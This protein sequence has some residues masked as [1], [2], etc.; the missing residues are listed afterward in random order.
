MNLTITP[1]IQNL[2]FRQS[3]NVSNPQYSEKYPNL[4]PLNQDTV[5][6][7]GA[8]L[9][10][11]EAAESSY[12]SEIPR[13]KR[14]A[15]V[16]L[17]ALESTANALKKDKISFDRAYAN[18]HA[19]KSAKSTAD[20]AERQKNFEV[21]DRVRST[22]YVDNPYDVTKL[23]KIL[24]EMK[25]RGYVLDNI[26][27]HEPDKE[28]IP[29]IDLRLEDINE[30]NLGKLSPQLQS[31]VSHPCKSGYEDIQMRF[32]RDYVDKSKQVPHELLLLFGPNYAKAKSL[33]E[34]LVYNP[35]RDLDEI[36]ISFENITNKNTKKIHAYKDLI[37]KMLRGKISQKLFLNAKNKDFYKINDEA[38]IKFSPDDIIA[39]NNYFNG[40]KVSVSRYYSAEA[41]RSFSQKAKRE[42]EKSRK[43]D[44]KIINKS[45]ETLT[46][47]IQY[48]NKLDTLKSAKP[49]L[50][51]G[52][53]P[54]TK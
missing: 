41:R 14:L 22:L 53:K 21:L 11:K 30:E 52:I 34:D 18:K 16:F 38:V 31:R 8:V 48:F 44:L 39:F 51:S 35:L 28:F 7:T 12:G 5:N 25:Q 47:T 27:K 50:K 20:K 2:R 36:H 10:M 23:N 13:L 24:V 33:E 1:L 46:K 6:F 43:H 45:H 19:V 49:E 9:P 26:N 40:L 17:D 3:N 37:C 32:I 15:T 42:I 29:D 4:Q 54:A